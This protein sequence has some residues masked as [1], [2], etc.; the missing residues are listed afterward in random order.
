MPPR[1]NPEDD[2]PPPPTMSQVLLAIQANR[3]QSNRL[4]EQ[5]LHNSAPRDN[6]C[7]TLTDFLRTQAPQFSFAKEPLE[8]DDWLRALE[9]KFSALHVPDAEH[10]NF[11][12]YL[13]SGSAGAWWESH[14]SMSA[15]GHVFSW[16]E[17]RTAFRAPFIPKA[18]MDQKR[19][20]FPDLNQGR[21]DVRA[22]GREF[23][24]LA[25]YAPRDVTNDR[26]EERRVGKEC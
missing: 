18:D 17:F 2:L 25:R 6:C 20:E 22:Y 9:R 1:Q 23:D 13:L 8:A 16:A 10:V 24:R 5:L 19:N 4:L 7:T 14:M 15:A 11:A 3:E 26:S 21:I 12:T